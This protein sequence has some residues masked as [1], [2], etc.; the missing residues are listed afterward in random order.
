MDEEKM[1]N[2]RYSKYRSIG[3]FEAQK[4]QMPEKLLNPSN[5]S[6]NG[7]DTGKN[8]LSDLARFLGLK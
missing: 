8:F 6:S 7:S 1:K 5:G 3:F 4:S 2:Q